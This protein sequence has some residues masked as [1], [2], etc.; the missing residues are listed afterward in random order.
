MDVH[1]FTKKEEIAHAITHGIGAILSIAALVLLIVFASFQGNPVLIVSVTIFGVTMLLMY[2]S[3]TIVHSLPKNK[4]KN[5]FLIVDH[6]SIYLFIAGTYT[7]FVL[8]LINGKIGWTLFGIVWGIAAVGI[9]MKLF[10]VKK[11]V[12]LSTLTYILM[13]WI[14]VFAWGPLTEALH[15][16]G[17]KLLVAG[18]VVYT[19][20]A[21]FYVWKKVPY[22][23]VIWHLFVV[24]GS[25]LHFF[26]VLFYVI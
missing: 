22:H 26:A 5:A 25:V 13:G 15:T 23:H 7:P 14:I 17:V 2:L 8:A 4:W 6:A 16:N 20:G 1:T 11:F 18:G 19:I 21:I 10:F 9:I 24:A 3:S 12:I